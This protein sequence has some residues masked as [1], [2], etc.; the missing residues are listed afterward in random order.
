MVRCDRYERKKRNNYIAVLL[1]NLLYKLR[2]LRLSLDEIYKILHNRAAKIISYKDLK[3]NDI[4]LFAASAF[5]WLS[6][7]T[8]SEYNSI[9][10]NHSDGI[11]YATLAQ[12]KE[13]LIGVEANKTKM[14]NYI[15]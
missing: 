11:F 4:N 1:K 9:C 3:I 14:V 8:I 13:E 6:S 2:G 10:G 7:R 15:L 5:G 12:M